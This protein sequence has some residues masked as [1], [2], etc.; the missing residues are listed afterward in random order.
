MTDLGLTSLPWI[1][2]FS[3]AL[4]GSLHCAGMC[5]PLVLLAASVWLRRPWLA[6]VG[7]VFAVL[8]II[9]ARYDES[10]TSFLLLAASTMT[11]SDR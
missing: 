7:F 4:L 8:A 1:A 11:V 10:R 6:G 5:G 2:A 9:A 3:A